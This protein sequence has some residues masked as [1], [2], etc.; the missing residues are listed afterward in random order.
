M[1]VPQT[2]PGRPPKNIV[3]KA[4]D[5]EDAVIITDEKIEAAS[6]RDDSF[7]EAEGVPAPK[8]QEEVYHN[9]ETGTR[10]NFMDESRADAVFADKA[11]AFV[12]HET[13]A[14]KTGWTNATSGEEIPLQVNS[15]SAKELEDVAEFGLEVID[16]FASFGFSKLAGEEDTSLFELPRN[17]KIKLSQML[18]IILE[19]R[20][21]GSGMSIEL[22]FLVTLL[23]SY[24]P[25]LQ[26][27]LSMKSEKNK[28]A[29][30]DFTDETPAIRGPGRPRKNS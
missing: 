2:K 11:E 28:I 27:A 1:H 29:E 4:Q 16:T 24:G 19:K 23:L 26:K 25:M 18:S 13:D 21:V 8:N 7:A 17:K 3:A 12:P 10:V 15:F 20:G 14:D 22:M 6:L 9:E 5:I 30:N